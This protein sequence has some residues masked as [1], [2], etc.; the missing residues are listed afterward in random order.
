MCGSVPSPVFKDL[1]R[2]RVCFDCVDCNL[3]LCSGVGASSSEFDCFCVLA[4]GSSCVSSSGNPDDS[5]GNN[6]SSFLHSV[7]DSP[8]KLGSGSLAESDSRWDP[9][10]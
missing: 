6:I 2:L 9:C 4:N 5:V 10:V 1:E 7:V 8:V 3:D